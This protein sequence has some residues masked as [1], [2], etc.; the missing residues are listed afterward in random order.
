LRFKP[1][2]FD[3]IQRH[4]YAPTLLAN[5]VINAINCSTLIKNRLKQSCRTN[6]HSEID[7]ILTLI[8]GCVALAKWKNNSTKNR[9]KNL[10][11]RKNIK[12]G[13]EGNGVQMESLNSFNRSV[14]NAGYSWRYYIGL[15]F[16]FNTQI[17]IFW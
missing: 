7:F 1:F 15:N 11:H 16:F 2:L 4:V 8:R 10:I 9:G 5:T 17:Q 3:G 6:T 12:K 14:K 13:N